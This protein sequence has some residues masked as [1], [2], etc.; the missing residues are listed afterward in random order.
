MDYEQR[1]ERI[2]S[3]S[4]DRS[5]RGIRN[6]KNATA[7]KTNKEKEKL[8]PFKMAQRAPKVAIKKRRSLKEIRSIAMGALV[9][10]EEQDLEAVRTS[11]MTIAQRGDN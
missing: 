1:L 7:S 2:K 4:E 6:R 10:L 8:K 9:S 5:T 3:G 11:L